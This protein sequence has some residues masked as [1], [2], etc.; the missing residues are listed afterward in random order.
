[1]E[2]SNTQGHLIFI[3]DLNTPRILNC[4]IGVFFGGY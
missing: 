3:L 2:Q 4:R 1:M